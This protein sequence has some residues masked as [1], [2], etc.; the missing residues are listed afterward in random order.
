M[1]ELEKNGMLKVLN[2][3]DMIKVLEEIENEIDVAFYTTIGNYHF[4]VSCI[5]PDIIGGW[6]TS[7]NSSNPNIL[8]MN[9]ILDFNVQLRCDFELENE[10]KIL[11]N[12]TGKCELSIIVKKDSEEEKT[13]KNSYFKYTEAND[14]SKLRMNQITNADDKCL[15]E[16]YIDIIFTFEPSDYVFSKDD[17][18]QLVTLRKRLLA[19]PKVYEKLMTQLQIMKSFIH[20]MGLNISKSIKEKKK[21]VNN[22]EK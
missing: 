10:D 8:Y 7:R 13:I 5:K 9:D 19:F 11:V 6:R 16:N 12:E 3:S 15:P 2:E 1:T 20:Y 21:E 17:F 14:K 18:Y 4:Q 22:H